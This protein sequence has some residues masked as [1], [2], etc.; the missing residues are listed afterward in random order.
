[1]AIA[2]GRLA[3]SFV[4]IFTRFIE[5]PYYGL[6]AFASARSRTTMIA[7]TGV[8]LAWA[9]VPRRRRP[10]ASANVLQRVVDLAACA[11]EAAA[12]ILLGGDTKGRR[13]G[14]P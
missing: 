1:M 3:I 14:T 11:L 12:G 13:A 5:V 4:I 10:V 8:L 9:V 7:G 2:R 6:L